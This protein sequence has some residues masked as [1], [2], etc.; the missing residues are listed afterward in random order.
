LYEIEKQDLTRKV[1]SYILY[2]RK[3]TLK[4]KIYYILLFRKL[5]LFLSVVLMFREATDDS[6][7]D[8]G[9]CL[10]C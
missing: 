1:N 3:L 4:V 7:T 9:T 2:K 5:T 6:T 8:L 10:E